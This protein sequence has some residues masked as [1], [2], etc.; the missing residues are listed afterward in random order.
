M[1]VEISNL[2]ELTPAD[3]S[4]NLDTLA[5]LLQ[6]EF[7]SI[8]LKRGVL[9]DLVLYYSAIFATKN[10]VEMAR[11]RKSLSLTEIAVDPS[12][13]DTATVDKLAANYSVI[14]NEGTSASG[15]VNIVIS[16]R[17][18][19]TI[20]LGTTFIGNGKTFTPNAAYTARALSVD[21][22]GV[23]DRLITER[24]DNNF[25]FAIEV[26]AEEVGTAPQLAKDTLLTP[27][28]LPPNY[29]TAYAKDDFIG[30]VNYEDNEKLLAKFVNGISAK[31]MSSRTNMSALLAENYP[32]TIADSI[33]GFGDAEMH[34]DQHSIIPA[35][36]GGRVDWYI[37]SDELYREYGDVITATLIALPGDNTSTWQ[38]S[39]SRDTYSGL[40]DVGV[41]PRVGEYSDAF[42]ILEDIRSMDLTALPEGQLIPDIA[43][44]TE[45]V[46]SRFQ[47]VTIRFS[48][49][50]K[51]TSTLTIGDTADYVISVRVLANLADMQSLVSS[52]DVRN[53]AGDILVKAPIP[54]FLTLSFTITKDETQDDVDTDAIA[55]AL[56]LFVNTYG[57]SKT[58][59]ASA[60]LDVI[61]NGLT[62]RSSVSAIDIAGRIR[63]PDG[64]TQFLRSSESLVLPA[65]P[66]KMG[67]WRTI[68]F[69]LSPDDV[70]ISEVAA[71]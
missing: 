30:G 63:Y 67:T 66:A 56:A 52:R 20:G 26:T 4:Q 29:V 25:E 49:V 36:L 54:C 51:D 65:V 5:Q 37:R 64:S 70:G 28:T 42:T 58:L 13:A 43:T 9:H 57:F 61:H 71:S 27:S 21:L 44:V 15:S 53:V 12:L 11:L 10:Q 59:P 35:S 7:P 16:S 62:G 47:T 8:D 23:N 6:E 45:A 39:F 40:Y 48:D 68:A 55:D 17:R 19:M 2:S 3:V 18:D 38:I 69:F 60:L 32:E 50:L 41:Y 34:R 31:V 14:R 33:I 22:I 1:A 24:N 46:Y